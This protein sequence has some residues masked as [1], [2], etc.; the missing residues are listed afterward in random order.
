[1]NKSL[2][3]FGRKREI[4]DLRALHGLRRHVLIVGPAGIGKSALLQRVRREL[5]L[6]ISEDSSSLSRICDSFERQLGW[7][8]RKLNVIT[9]KNQLF[10]CLVRRGEPVAFDHLARTPPRV[11]RFIAHLAEQVPIWIACRSDRPN[12]IGNIWPELYKF[13]R[14]ELLPLAETDTRI[15]I[16]EAVAR[17]TIQADAREHAEELHRM[18]GG[19]PRILE[20]LLIELAAR[21]YHID[22]SFGLNLLD[23]DRRIHEITDGR[24]SNRPPPLRNPR[25]LA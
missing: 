16:E 8:H 1:M 11:A 17:G 7:N 21:E 20:E 14:I 12:E 24:F 25:S 13:M 5:S 23:L 15:L 3:F 19:N 10:A 6:L 18:S 9:R 2:A 22:C 4:D